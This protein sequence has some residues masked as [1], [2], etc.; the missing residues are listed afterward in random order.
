MVASICAGIALLGLLC[1]YCLYFMSRPAQSAGLE[2]LSRAALG[3]QSLVVVRVGSRILLI[4][5]ADTGMTKLAELSSEEAAALLAELGLRP[6]QGAYVLQ[7][8]PK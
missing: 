7:S 8:D 3:R 4:G 2:V 5:V 1:L 6:R